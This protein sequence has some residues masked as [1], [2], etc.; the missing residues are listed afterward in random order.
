[1][2][3]CSQVFKELDSF[4]EHIKEHECE[5]TYR[6]HICSKVFVSLYELGLHQYTHSLYPQQGP[7]TGPRS[8][9]LSLFRLVNV[10]FFACWSLRSFYMDYKIQCLFF[11]NYSD[12]NSLRSIC[13]NASTKF[14]V[15][16]TRIFLMLFR[17]KYISKL[18]TVQ[19]VLLLNHQVYWW[20]FFKFK[21][22]LCVI[23][24]LK[25]KINIRNHY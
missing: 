25:K 6:C 3:K 7:K 8:D 20:K 14:Y 16:L 9:I 23:Y 17:S 19:I 21:L 4:L 1:M 12:E 13:V 5:M 10:Y 15:R 18:E 22:C 2:A 24:I 11:K